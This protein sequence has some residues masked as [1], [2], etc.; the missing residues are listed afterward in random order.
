M[1]KTLSLAA[2]VVAFACV[3]PAQQPSPAQPIEPGTLAKSDNDILAE[4]ESKRIFGV[5]PNYRSAPTIADFE[6]L[7][8]VQKF[9]IATQDAFDRGTFELAAVLGGV[10]QLTNSNKSFGQGTTG[11]GKYFGTAFGD[12]V[13]GNYMTEGI[14]PS[15]LHQDPRYFRRETG[16]GWS[17]LKYS[18]GQILW[19]H[20][21]SG[22]TQFNYS[23]VIGNSTAVAISNAYYSENRTPSNAVGKL[24]MQ[25][26]LDMAGNVL[27]E[28][29]PDIA[30]KFRKKHHDSD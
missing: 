27:K 2:S 14:Y 22:R 25:L 26:G 30:G 17:R 21:D 28:F 24:G 29:W 12:F 18:I 4:T 7:T 20:T 6:P 10:G 8:P 19:T 5:I 15:I 9:K 1:L 23:E 3:L 16:T 13:I 11:F